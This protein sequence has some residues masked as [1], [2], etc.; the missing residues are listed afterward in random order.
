ML[1]PHHMKQDPSPILQNEANSNGIQ[2]AGVVDL[3]M[4][5]HQSEYEALSNY[6]PAGQ[7][8][9][10]QSGHSVEN[11]LNQLEAARPLVPS[12]KE[13]EAQDTSFVGTIQ[14]RASIIATG[15]Q[16]MQQQT[17]NLLAAATTTTLNKDSLVTANGDA[18]Q[19]VS[20]L[21]SVNTSPLTIMGHVP[22]VVDHVETLS[23]P[24]QSTRPSP[25]VAVP[26]KTMLLEAL[27]PNPQ[28]LSVPTN[29]VVTATNNVVPEPTPEDNLLTT[30]NAALLPPIQEA[31]IVSASNSSNGTVSVPSQ[32][33]LQVLHFKP[34]FNLTFLNCETSQ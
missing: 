11:Y 33:P 2:G 20:P 18:H 24:Q 25:P 14:Q 31:P 3:R 8:L 30:I 28:P 4:K 17:S 9:P 34:Y 27:L 21:R 15:R 19:I 10:T 13:Q 6:T 22:P 12:P 26:V 29:S 5:H 23:S 1:S 7:P 16:Q 32:I